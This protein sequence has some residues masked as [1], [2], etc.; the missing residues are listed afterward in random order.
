MQKSKSVRARHATLL[1]ETGYLLLFAFSVFHLLALASYSPADPGWSLVLA[2]KINIHNWGGVFGSY[3][4]DASFRLVGLAAFLPPGLLIYVVI[5]YYLQQQTWSVMRL[6]WGVILLT[7]G[8]ATMLSLMLP[9]DPS[10]VAPFSLG[11][12]LGQWLYQRMRMVTGIAG[13]WLMVGFGLVIGLGLLFSIT[14]KSYARLCV[15]GWHLFTW[16]GRTLRACGQ[17]AAIRLKSLPW[18]QWLT[19]AHRPH[20]ATRPEVAQPALQHAVAAKVLGPPSPMEAVLPTATDERAQPKEEKFEKIIFRTPSLDLL[21]II[22]KDGKQVSKEV[23]IENAKILEKKLLDFG[24]QGKVTEIQPG[25][26]ITL[27]EYAP[28]AGIKVNKISQLADDLAL[29]LSALSVRIVAPIPGKA[30]VGIEISNPRREMVYFSEICNCEAYKHATSPLTLALGKDI[31]GN[32]VITDLQKMPHL[33]IAGATGSGK[34]VAVNTMI[35]SILYRALPTDVR[36]L[37][38]DPKM[39]ELSLYA[40]IPHLLHPVITDPKHAAVALRWLV[41]EMER[42]YGLMA[43][44][45]VRNIEGY[46]ARMQRG[47]LL[48][49]EHRGIL[50]FIVVVIDE[51]ADLMIVNGRKI[52]LLSIHIQN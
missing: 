22:T 45:S 15:R 14:L 44:L 1:T 27:Y 9:Q 2:Q 28:A 16:A 34:S 47:D 36:F 3:L 39:L 25:P 23:L 32:P 13:V 19:R 24:V 35:L 41:A 11:G 51:L 5:R 52:T 21:P 43:D 42:R 18:R 31:A 37:M 7:F 46:N 20:V 49:E 50:P 29:A 10:Q 26:V 38:I 17:K 6:W 40:E 33:L 30:V 8:T 4:A 48:D 12:Y